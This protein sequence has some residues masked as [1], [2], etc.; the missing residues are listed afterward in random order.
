MSVYK[1]AS[2]NVHE[3]NKE[4]NTKTGMKNTKGRYIYEGN[5]KIS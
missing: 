3:T 5:F 1:F 2:P 4:E